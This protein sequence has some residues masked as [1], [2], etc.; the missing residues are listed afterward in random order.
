MGVSHIER[1]KFTYGLT[2]K[3]ALVWII[4]AGHR[5]F[6]TAFVEVRKL[7]LDHGQTDGQT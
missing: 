7:T 4:V 2:K 3:Q 1:H 5:L 6:P